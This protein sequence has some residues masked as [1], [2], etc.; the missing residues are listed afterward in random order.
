MRQVNNRK[1]S[2]AEV[3]MKTSFGYPGQAYQAYLG[4]RRTKWLNCC[5]IVIYQ[6]EA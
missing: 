5:L 2:G 6:N 1:S 4:D 3:P